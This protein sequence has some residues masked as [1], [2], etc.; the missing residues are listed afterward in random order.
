MLPDSLFEGMKAYKRQGGRAVLF[1]P[2]MNMARMRRSAE[3]VALPVIVGG[4]SVLV[5]T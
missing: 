4:D 1:R 2:E 3:R 5:Q